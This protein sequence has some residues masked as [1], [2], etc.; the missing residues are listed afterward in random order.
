MP[1][2]LIL[3]PIIIPIISG[4]AI[5]FIRFKSRVIKQIFIMSTVLVN[6]AITIALLFMR[7]NQSFVL[8]SITDTIE[9]TLRIDSLGSVFAL[10][11]SIMWPLATLYAFEYMRHEN[12]LNMFYCFYTMTFGVTLGIAFSANP[13]TM[14]LFYEFLTLVTTPLVLHTQN[15][16]AVLASRKYLF[17]SIA[18]AAVGFISISYVLI[19]GDNASFLF[20][21]II[22]FASGIGHTDI[23][24]LTYILAF[25]GFGV[26]AAVFPFHGWLPSASVAPT[27]VTALLHAVAVVK[28]GVFVIIRMTYYVYG[29]QTLNGTL[30]QH[31]VIILCVITVIYASVKAVKEQYFKRRLAYSTISN[32]SYILLGVTLMTEHG[33]LAALIHM[34]FHAFMKISAFFCA[35]AVLE[36]SEVRYV[37]QLE[38]M[39]KKMPFTFVCFTISSLALMGMPPLVGFISKYNLMS[40]A[41]EQGGFYSYLMI[42]TLFF[43]AVMVAVYLVFICVKA[44]F[45]NKNLTVMSAHDP[46]VMMRIPIAIFT[47][48]VIVLAV[49]SQPI[50]DYL[51]M[52]ASGAVQ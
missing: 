19:Y 25:T 43:S 49:F 8:L 24:E 31:I 52:V 28:S 42:F 7:P 47:S 32:L 27:P 51:S 2:Q 18:G 9:L 46:G 11:V 13:L 10:L 5:F 12:N 16:E 17:Y 23:M 4:L 26:K 6:S 44:F 22:N 38:G 39:G 3:L 34:I 21:G 37:N 15:K 36:Y 20:G 40:A 41:V 50:I 29:A 14:Y 35:G 48:C 1:Y 33:L 30:A 45:P